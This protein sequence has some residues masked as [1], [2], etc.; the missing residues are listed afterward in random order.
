MLVRCIRPCL[1]RHLN[2]RR[3]LPFRL[4]GF[5]RKHLLTGI[6]CAALLIVFASTAHLAWRDKCATFDEPTHFIASVFQCQQD[7]FR[8]DP[9]NPPLWRY[10]VGLWMHPVSID[11]ADSLWNGMLETRAPEG[12]FVRKTLYSTPGND[13][14]ALIAAARTRMTIL[15]CLLGIVTAWW[16]WRLAG[17]VAALVA[18]S[19]FC[20]DPNFLAHAP[21]VKNDVAIA[22]CFMLLMAAVWLIGERVTALRWLAAVLTACAAIGT[23]S[24]GI[25]ALPMM[26]TALFARSMMPQPWPVF[27]CVADTRLKRAAT[28]AMLVAPVLP[29]AWLS[30][31]A[32]YQFRFGPAPAPNMHFALRDI[33]LSLAKADW[34]S[35]H[36]GAA[37][38]PE[39]T[40][41]W[42]TSWRPG[43]S[44]HLALWALSHHLLPETSLVGFLHLY[45]ISRQRLG[46]LLGQSSSI[47]WWYYFPLAAAFKTPLSI[48]VAVALA[49][50]YR[51]R[52]TKRPISLSRWPLA[53]LLIGPILYGV[54]AMPSQVSAGIR[55]ILVIY[56]FVYVWLGVTAAAAWRSRPKSTGAIV[57]ILI[58]G[59]AVETYAAFPD[60]IPF[61]NVA[62]GSQGKL[63]LLGDSNLDWGQDLPA[64]AAWQRANPGTQLY[65]CYF[66]T[67][68]PRYYGIHYV[69][70]HSSMAPPDQSAPEALRQ[71]VA[72]SA[73]MLQNPLVPQPQRAFFRSLQSRQPIAILG[74]SIYLYSAVP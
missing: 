14:D 52:R 36:G 71:I 60:F 49:A 37:Y 28:A 32:A 15:G 54:V 73:S 74:G 47:G 5:T 66:G 44:V 9:E 34:D 59:L 25:L 22:L 27:R 10:Y 38:P 72:V 68:D 8:A 53:A 11:R 26:A 20:L 6:A 16:A 7:D 67:A 56:P 4:R 50:V 42:T 1:I 39:V 63:K 48:C 19:A 13:P 64:L 51:L 58:L 61:F 29:M 62:A 45:A 17:P 41:Q 2:Q 24:S 33:L 30:I 18:L 70:L 69:N 3:N 35:A 12:A 65:L 46:F 43:V 23:K 31:W 57:A 40:A 21:L 55:H